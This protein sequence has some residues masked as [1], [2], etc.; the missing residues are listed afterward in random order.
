MPLA[1]L[2][3][4]HLS[5]PAAGPDE[6]TIV[7]PTTPPALP[8]VALPDALPAGLQ[9]LQIQ[10]ET[11]APAAPEGGLFAVLLDQVTIDSPVVQAAAPG[12]RPVMLSLT[13][14]TTD[15]LLP[16]T[17]NLLPQLIEATGAAEAVP[18][19]QLVQ[20]PVEPAVELTAAVTDD[21]TAQAQVLPLPPLPMQVQLKV[22][23]PQHAPVIDVAAPAAASS[24]G[25]PAVSVSPVLREQPIRPAAELQTAIQGDAPRD[26]PVLSM[27]DQTRPQVQSLPSVP[28]PATAPA[29]A[30]DS[31]VPL[32]AVTSQPAQQQ[33]AL[34]PTQ[35]PPQSYQLNHSV[36]DARWGDAL[37]QR[38]VW[39]S[40]AG[41]GRAEIRLNPPELG[42]IDVRV[43]VANDEA[44]VAFN[45]Q[46]GTTREALEAALP[47]LRELFAQQGIELADA[48]VSQHSPGEQRQAGTTA[49]NQS[50]ISSGEAGTGEGAGQTESVIPL[51]DSLID[52]YA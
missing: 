16:Q 51:G 36:A 20:P 12:A 33:P 15:E 3:R 47:R 45:V 44:R 13:A 6:D 24:A 29:P 11:P 26:N 23:A 37:G 30:M 27:Q 50:G 35:A 34:Q 41:I 46:H 38:L 5:G 25:E 43:A 4:R 42:Y 31:H 9:T 21:T 39:M 22:L 1:T 52:T 10:G 48:S 18:L 2:W 40:E 17:G 8:F 28:Q 49:D 14:A 7:G 32:T 19:P